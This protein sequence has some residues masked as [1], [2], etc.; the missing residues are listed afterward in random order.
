MNGTVVAPSLVPDDPAPPVVAALPV[1]GGGAPPAP[2]DGVDH[3]LLCDGSATVDL[4]LAAVQ[5]LLDV[6]RAT[7]AGIV[8]P[9]L[10]DAD[11]R[12]R[13]V[14]MGY[15]VTRGGAVAHL[16]EP[17]ELDQGQHDGTRD[18]FAVPGECLLV[19]ADLLRSVGFD[20]ALSAGRPAAVVSLCWR[21]RTAGAA[22][23]V[24]SDAVAAV[25][26][27]DTVRPTDLVTPTE[28]VR[29]VVTC[30]G[31]GHRWRVVPQVVAAQV[32][33][34]ARALVRA[35]PAAA[36]APVGAWAVNLA[37]VRSRWAVRGRVR[38]ARRTPD[39]TVRRRQAPGVLQARLAARRGLPGA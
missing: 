34:A 24:T 17:G 6:A 12:R 13:L 29:L 30:Y 9:K 25:R 37:R 2:P 16:V 36:V 8:G 38:R 1:R 4:D 7:G 26:R 14:G 21:A 10:V 5:A 23:V 3:L 31:L 27:P 33:G 22:V 28:Q 18:V 15:A 11:D 20:P 35:R 19:R 32:W 39:R